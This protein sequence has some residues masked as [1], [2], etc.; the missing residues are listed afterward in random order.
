MARL[1]KDYTYIVIDN[2]AGLEH[3]SRRTTR[4]ADVLVAV[5]DATP[6]G[7]R[8]VKRI[9]DLVKDLEIKTKKNLLLVNRYD[10]EIEKE[11][12]KDL[13]LDYLG[14]IPEDDRISKISL[15]G[16]SLMALKEDAASLKALR[17]FGEKIWVL[18]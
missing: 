4:A 2:E 15:N 18:H 12:I 7:L 6:I 5:S 17:K 13:G 14:Y 16:N 3:L 8:A 11:K 10:K 9:R 1:I